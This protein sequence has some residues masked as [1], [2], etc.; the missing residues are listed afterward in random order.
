MFLLYILIT[1]RNELLS[2][3]KTKH[4]GGVKMGISETDFYRGKCDVC[5]LFID[6]VYCD[7]VADGYKCYGCG[8]VHKV[9]FEQKY[10]VRLAHISG[11]I[12]TG[13]ITIRTSISTFIELL[14]THGWCASE[15]T[16]LKIDPDTGR[17]YEKLSV[18]TAKA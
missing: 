18:S 12:K 11:A 13:R 8:E 14:G 17:Y 6:S 5:G 1:K 7:K 15:C 2:F 3:L 16:R 9:N 10:F 4:Y